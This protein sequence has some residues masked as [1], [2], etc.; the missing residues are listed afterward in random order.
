[1]TLATS[2]IAAIPAD[3][4]GPTSPR[5][6]RVLDTTLSTQ[7]VPASNL[8]GNA[9]GAS[10][11][12][13]LPSL[14]I[15]RIVC[16]G[17]AGVATLRTLTRAADDVV[18][19]VRSGRAAARLRRLAG[20]LA[21]ST[22]RVVVWEGGRLP[23][24][25]ACTDL[26]L[27]T[28]TAPRRLVRNPADLDEIGRV[29]ARTGVLYIERSAP[30]AAT[31]PSGLGEAFEQHT[32]LVTPGVGEAQTA[33]PATDAMTRAYFADHRLDQPT[34]QG[35][36]ATRAYRRL[37][38]WLLPGRKASRRSILAGRSQ[39]G[40]SAGPPKYLCRIAA[41]SG[42]DIGG[43]RW[44]ISA[45]GGYDSRK[46]VFM[47]FAP[48]EPAPRYVV[49]L[50]R[51][52]ALNPRLDNERGALELLAGVAAAARGSVPQVVFAGRHRGLAVL[53]ETAIEGESLRRATTAT[54]DCPLGRA[55]ADWLLD[56]G[57]S[58]V[59]ER[60][61]DPDDL[62]HALRDVLER[63]LAIYPL[64][65]HHARFLRQQV[66]QVA[67][68][69][70][71][72]PV[73]FQH[74]D[75]GIWNVLATGPDTVA[76]LDWE[77]AEPRGIPLWDLLYFLRSFAV[78]GITAHGRRAR[79]AALARSMLDDSAWSRMAA[80]ACGRYARALGI[81]PALLE[82][83]YHTCWVHRALKEA[84]RLPPSRLSSGHYVQLL[85]A[86]IDR[87]RAPAMRRLFAATDVE[88]T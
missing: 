10:W 9:A 20:G 62:A 24:A 27:L 7:F 32:L 12:F 83:L 13:A 17:A 25:D 29:L 50:T 44:G 16:I 80:G 30:T 76:F 84:T 70:D 88:E 31:S 39:A 77:A 74:G 55:A 72:L 8:K 69:R 41:A 54:P 35:T 36:R 43:W 2:Q 85:L 14:E 60:S 45:P 71:P 47:L 61:C 40:L 68:S 11:S 22:L 34:F 58:T 81:D 79:F 49:K 15:D 78:T 37:H 53:G 19:L 42:I 86:G 28:D 65:N 6:T 33:V 56:L 51:H 87:R 18:L 5:R 4:D 67:A 3:A 21:A 52:A 23:L 57:Q 75:P 73:V 66:E 64:G 82:P 59:D 63:F 1:M 38:T 48:Q 26:V 46:V